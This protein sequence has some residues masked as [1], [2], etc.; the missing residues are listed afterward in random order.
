M[1]TRPFVVMGVNLTIKWFKEQIY[2]WGNKKIDGYIK[3]PKI[4][5][6]QWEQI[7][8]CGNNNVLFVG[9]YIWL[10]EQKTY[11]CENK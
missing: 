7:Y 1:G 6:W 5:I 11:A 4:S 3:N 8:G 10:W 9:T 2:H